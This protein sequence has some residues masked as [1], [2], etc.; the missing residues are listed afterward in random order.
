[1]SMPLR[2]LAL[3]MLGS[4]VLAGR[5]PAAAPEAAAD[6]VRTAVTRGL[7]L[8]LKGAIG[9]TEQRTCFACHSQALPMLALSAAKPRG[10]AVDAKDV[11]KQL[12]FIA[13]FLGRNRDQ[14]R[15][16]Q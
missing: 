10:F 13:G 1:M 3:A 14:F 8:L 16:G 4:F 6:P 9:H 11:Q 2:L 7:P 12:Q 5:L 15:Q